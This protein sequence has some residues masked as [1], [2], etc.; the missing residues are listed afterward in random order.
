VNRPEALEHLYLWL[1]LALGLTALLG[2]SA[3]AE[4]PVLPRASRPDPG[5][6]M[7]RAIKEWDACRG[8]YDRKWPCIE[9]TL[10]K[11]GQW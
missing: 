8:D 11:H 5:A 3:C 6:P 2:A 10:K 4:R 9:A 1:A 7:K